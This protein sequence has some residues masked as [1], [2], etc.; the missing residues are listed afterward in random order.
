MHASGHQGTRGRE[1]GVCNPESN[2]FEGE[3]HG[4]QESREGGADDPECQDQNEPPDIPLSEQVLCYKHD[5][6]LNNQDSLE[7]RSLPVLPLGPL[8]EPPA[9]PTGT[10][11]VGPPTADSAALVD[12]DANHLFT[13]DGPATRIG[14]KRKARDLHAILQGCVCGEV[15]TDMEVSNG[16]HVIRCKS[17]GCETGWVSIE[18]SRKRE[19]Y[20]SHDDS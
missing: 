15:V 16:E 9:F 3:I 10:K 11:V 7:P 19:T 6:T 1:D 2:D 8:V 12:R 18:L 5:N 17:V 20:H 4:H 13:L 14:R